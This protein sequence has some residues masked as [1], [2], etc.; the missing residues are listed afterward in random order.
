MNDTAADIYHIFN[1]KTFRITQ[2][3][4]ISNLMLGSV[5]LSK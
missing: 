3:G 2:E 4:L 1:K 5:S